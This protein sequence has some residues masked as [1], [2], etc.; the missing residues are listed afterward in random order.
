MHVHGKAVTALICFFLLCRRGAA[1]GLAGIVKGLGVSAINGYGVLDALKQ[2]LDD[3]GSAEAREGALFAFEALCEKLG[4]RAPHN[5]VLH[6][7]LCGILPFAIRVAG[8][9]VNGQLL[10]NRLFEPYIVQLM[11]KLLE[12]F[13]DVSAS[14]RKATNNVARGIMGNLSSQGADDVLI[15]GYCIGPSHQAILCLECS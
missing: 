4:R 14:V 5:I 1:F 10:A 15:K 11:G 3:Q 13:G 2:A 6:G 9:S 7:A 8:S 12:R